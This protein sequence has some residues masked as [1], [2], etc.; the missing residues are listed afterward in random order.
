MAVDVMVVLEAP[1]GASGHP[2]TPETA[3]WTRTFKGGDQHRVARPAPAFH[4]G[5]Q[6]VHMKHDPH[7]MTVLSVRDRPHR[8][9]EVRWPWPIAAGRLGSGVA[10]R[11][12]LRHAH[13]HE[14]V[15]PDFGFVEMGQCGWQR[16]PVLDARLRD[17]A[18]EPLGDFGGL[19]DGAPLGHEAWNIRARGQESA[20]GQLL[21][22]EPDR[23]FAHRSFCGRGGRRWRRARLLGFY[24]ECVLHG[25]RQTP[26]R[27]GQAA[28]HVAGVP[29]AAMK[30]RRLRGHDVEVAARARVGGDVSSARCRRAPGRLRATGRRG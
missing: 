10:A 21:D 9:D 19:R 11:P 24:R 30:W 5:N 2:H 28:R 3:A 12:A 16:V 4:G 26:A 8:T 13:G 27:V 20:V 1:P 23:C 7:R 18:G 29:A 22:V 17:L 6:H 14:Q 25:L 15:E